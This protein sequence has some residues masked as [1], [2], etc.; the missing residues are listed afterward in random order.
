MFSGCCWL[1]IV[2]RCVLFSVWLVFLFVVGV[3][4]IV[5]GCLLL[6]VVR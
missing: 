2:L 6:V 4:E 5:C 3:V 1:L